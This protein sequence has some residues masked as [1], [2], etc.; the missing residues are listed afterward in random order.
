MAE[1][2]A[3][4]NEYGQ[5]ICTNT[6]PIMPTASTDWE[7]IDLYNWT[8]AV[9][10]LRWFEHTVSVAFGSDSRM[11][12]IAEMFCPEAGISAWDTIVKYQYDRD[13]ELFEHVLNNFVAG[14]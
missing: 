4:V 12:R 1:G 6:V 9:P 8:L 13:D 3:R 11:L 10:A 5:T 7:N 2:E 14:M